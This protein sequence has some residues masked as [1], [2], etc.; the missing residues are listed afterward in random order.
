MKRGMEARDFSRV[1]LHI[2]ERFEKP[3]VA[4]GWDVIIFVPSE[5]EDADRITCGNTLIAK[6]SK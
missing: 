5:E 6:T 1:R 3:L 4:D 2:Y